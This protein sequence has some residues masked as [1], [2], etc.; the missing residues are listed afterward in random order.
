[1][2]YRQV[3][4]FCLMR[5]ASADGEIVEWIWNSRDGVTPF[6]VRSRDGSA[7]LTHIDWQHDIRNPYYR[8]R[9]GERV[10]VNANA[11]GDPRIVYARDA[12]DLCYR[13]PRKVRQG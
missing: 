1:M 5:Y 8:P 3:E 7:E 11:D 10:F 4:A 9:P 2:E 12:P 13:A 6:T